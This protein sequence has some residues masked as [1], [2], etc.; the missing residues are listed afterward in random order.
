MAAKKD[1]EKPTVKKPEDTLLARKLA[2]QAKIMKKYGASDDKPE[3][4][5][6]ASS[7]E[8]VQ[9]YPTGLE[10]FDNSV[11]GIGG[12][13]KGRLIELYGL[14]SSGKTALAMHLAAAVQR[15]D[16]TAIV[17]IYDLETAWTD[18]WGESMGLDLKRTLLP[19]VWGSEN[20]ANQI[21]ADLA[22]ELP[23]E[24]IIIDSIAVTQ[25]ESVK[26]KQISDRTMRDNLAR[27]Q[28][29]TVFFDSLT[30]GFVYPPR[31]KDKLLPKGARSLKLKHT[32]TTIMCIN[33]AKQRT[34]TIA[35]GKTITEWYSV[36]GVSLD[37]HSCIQLM[38][39]RIGFEGKGNA[40]THQKIRVTADKNKVAPPKKSC[41]IMLSFKGGMEQVGT[42][43]YLPM[44]VEKGLA[45]V[46][47]AWIKSAL[48]PDGKIQGKEAFNQFVDESPDTKKIFME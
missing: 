38:V 2:A 15:Q 10:V 17:K 11:L 47:G 29:L 25:P 34:K 33:H 8:P 7:S 22:S 12:L 30:D 9:F 21:H 45:T 40:V 42:I 6:V 20:M 27:A 35:T 39:V 36:G 48:L 5:R 46:A 26:E 41:E 37:F 16:Q 44:A 18:T 23:P 28:F 31:G 1:G 19:E 14:K 4:G 32:P 24:I 3:G 13:P 43:D